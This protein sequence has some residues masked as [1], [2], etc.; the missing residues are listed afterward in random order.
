M[1][2][3]PAEPTS[4]QEQS[5]SPDPAKRVNAKPTRILSVDLAKAAAICAVLL[6]H[7]SANHFAR[8][9]V[10]S[11][12]WLITN[13][14]G[15]VSRWAVP[16]FL[17]CS[18]AIMN[19]PNKDLPLKKLFSKYLLRLFTSLV[20]W[21]VLYEAVGV[22]RAQGSAPL[23]QLIA[24]AGKNLFYGN[25]H[26]HLYFFWFIFTL[27]FSLPLTRLVVRFAS[28]RELQYL[29]GLGF[30]FG[31]V[32]PFLQYY[33]PVNQ[34]HASL[35]YLVLPSAF[36]C[37]VLGMIGWYLHTHPPKGWLGSLLLF[38]GSLGVV[39]CGTLV[40]SYQKGNLDV[41]YFGGV[42]LFAVTMA[43]SIFRLCQFVSFRPFLR[44]QSFI[45]NSVTTLS[46]ASFCIYLIHPL[47]QEA[48]CPEWFL[49]SC[50]SFSIPLQWLML[51]TLSLLAYLML[52]KIPG[53]RSWF[54]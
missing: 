16:L 41:L 26:Y 20:F 42:S 19:D 53:I 2:I 18:G 33:P 48:I 14:F 5:D 44:S 24:A 40:R 35:L 3:S 50:V 9:E 47:L 30:L 12:S 43:I 27:Y 21:S 8:F 39:F 28:E 37:P 54:I 10:G 11:S 15:S 6:I 31:A 25:T 46:S 29:V 22:V 23:S 17:L 36:F 38:L 52:K 32:L 1:E 45:R 34:M 7:C 49:S 4:T 13:L 51:I